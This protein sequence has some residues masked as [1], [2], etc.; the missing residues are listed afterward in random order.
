MTVEDSNSSSD[1]DNY[2]SDDDEHDMQ[3]LLSTLQR[4]YNEVCSP[5]RSRPPTPGEDLQGAGSGD[6]GSVMEEGWAESDE[7]E[8]DS[9]EESGTRGLNVF[10]KLEETRSNLEDIIGMDK[11]IEAYTII[12]VGV[13]SVYSVCNGCEIYYCIK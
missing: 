4:V 2:V 1:D 5:P 3:Q 12:Q 8:S 6:N 10:V 9:E 7:D 11:L 13:M